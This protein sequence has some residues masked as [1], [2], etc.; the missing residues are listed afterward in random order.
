M[1]LHRVGLE[2]S[3]TICKI[4]SPQNFPLFPWDYVDGLWAMTSEGVGLS[5][6]AISFQDFQPMSSQSTEV[7]DGQMDNMR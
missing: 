5:V 6:R 4:F 3:S 1:S 2:S 7:T